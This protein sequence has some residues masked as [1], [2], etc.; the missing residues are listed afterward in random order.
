MDRIFA[1]RTEAGRL[2]AAEVAVH[3]AVAAT[4][5]GQLVVLGLPRGGVPIARE[6][7]HH[8]GAPLDVFV[9]RKLGA[10]WQPEL[11]V[12]AVASGGTRVL[13]DDIVRITGI[14]AAT[15]D[16]ITEAEAKV[17]VDRERAYRRERPALDVNG[18]TVIVVDDGLAT[19]ATMRAALE[20]LRAMGA[21][22][23]VA[24]VPVASGEAIEALRDHADAIVTVSVPPSF[25]AVGAWYRDF[26]QVSDAQVRDMLVA[27]E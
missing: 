13:N 2:L 8:L 3:A 5:P 14:D 10:P 4:A 15:V 12:G 6:V 22:R 24:A 25:T 19:G 11:A 16:K 27:D 1:D 23:L 17:V 7:A 9:V 21:A 18:M 26:H 20:A